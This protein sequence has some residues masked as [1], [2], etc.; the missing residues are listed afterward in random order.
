[1][2]ASPGIAKVSSQSRQPSLGSG[3]HIRLNTLAHQSLGIELPPRGTQG[4]CDRAVETQLA[5]DLMQRV[6]IAAGQGRVVL[7]GPCR[8]PDASQGPIQA[9]DQR[10]E[11]AI[12]QL[13]EAT[14]ATAGG[15]RRWG[16]SVGRLYKSE[17]MAL[18]PTSQFTQ[19]VNSHR[20][21]IA[22]PPAPNAN[23]SP[24]PSKVVLNPS[25]ICSAAATHPRACC[26]DN[27]AW[28][29]KG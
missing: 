21:S 25:A 6:D 3:A 9:I 10:I 23:V 27:R 1:M 5:P 14:R 17:H 7:D 16:D 19:P 26:L 24:R 12:L 11:V 18:E 29:S 2:T 20:A 22:E 13:V 4:P 15:C 28:T 8:V